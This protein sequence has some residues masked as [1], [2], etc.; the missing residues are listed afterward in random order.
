MFKKFG[1]YMFYLLNAPLKKRKAGKNQ[2]RIF[3]SV[4]GEIF[5]E[6]LEDIWKYRR[7]KMISLAEPLILEIIGQDRDMYRL[8]GETIEQF[9][10]RLQMKAIIAEMAGTRTGLLLALELIGY[11]GCDIIPLY[12][13]DRSR[14]AEIYID[15]P[16]LHDVNYNAILAEVLK[17]KTARTLPFFRFRYTVKAENKVVA[18]GGL[19]SYLKIKAYIAKSITGNADDKAVAAGMM[20]TTLYVKGG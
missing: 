19:G 14:W 12:E 2:F 10:Y 16:V 1:D 15:V 8:Q 13:T 4:V 17:V 9:R 5:D 18:V 6:M 11:P 3:F 20:H 7:Q